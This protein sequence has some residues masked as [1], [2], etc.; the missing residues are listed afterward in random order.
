M[1]RTSLIMVMSFSALLL[2]MG[3]RLSNV[4]TT[5]FENYEQYYDRVKSHNI[6]SSIANMACNVLYRVPNSSVNWTNISLSG[7]TA[8][9]NV[10]YWSSTNTSVDSI[11]RGKVKLLA[12]SLYNGY[13]DTIVIIWGQSSFSKFAYYSAIEGAIN[14][15]TKDTVF[16]P[17]HTQDKM[18]VNYSPVFMGKAT[19]KLGL[20]KNPSSS[21]PQ[22]LGGYQTGI[23]I[24]M[25]SDMNP[26]KNAA[27]S[28]GKYLKGKDLILNFNADGTLR[29]KEGSGPWTVTT[30][31]AYA[32]NGALVVDSGNVTIHG[33]FTGK[34][35]V[36]ALKNVVTNT[37]GKIFLDSSLVYKNNPQT[38]PSDDVLGLC[39]E[40]S[41]VIKQN[42]NNNSGI[43]IQAA[44]FS[45]TKGLGAENYASGSPRGTI[46]L[47]GGVS[48]KQ[49]AAVGTLD[50]S[51]NI[52]SGY[53][54]SYRYDERL[55]NQSPPFFPTTGSYEI[56]SW[57][58]H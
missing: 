47:L 22:F 26:L 2:M 49:R 38:G 31:S 30:I 53:S 1:G 42:S 4:S 35:T 54:K 7:G 21:T 39:G 5:A 11:F 16:G 28:A 58:E 19:N 3:Y 56:L 15:A 44:L 57:Y 50:G 52:V 27:L 14:W 34:L 46:Q 20:I 24:N 51:G 10:T 36:A 12:T 55:M 29:Y 41:L 18:T 43:K 40:D 23:D 45:L 17:F 9:V 13:R 8:N 6:A 48:Q 37:K 25:P 33:V 32:P